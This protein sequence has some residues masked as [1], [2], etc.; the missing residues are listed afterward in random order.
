VY[1]PRLTVQI[2]EQQF[3]GLRKHLEFG[4]Q[5]LL[6]GV[7]IDDLLELFERY[8]PEKVIGALVEKAISLKDISKLDLKNG[9][10]R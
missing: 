2:T 3:D 10:N 8:G 1:K 5:K 6:F 4:M 9:N 7:I